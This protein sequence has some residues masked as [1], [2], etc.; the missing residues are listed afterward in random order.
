MATRTASGVVGMTPGSRPRGRLIALEGIDGSGKS[1]V[2]PALGQ[3]LRKEGWTV[4]LRHEPADRSLGLLAQSASARD[5]WTG[6]IYFTIVRHLAR[7]ALDRDLATHDVVLTDRS[8]FSTLAYQGSALRPRDRRRLERLQRRVTVA[9][10]RVVLLDLDP[11]EALRRIGVRRE[12]R[13]PLERRAVLGRVAEAY[14]ALARRPGWVVVDAR[15]PREELVRALVARLRRTL[16]EP[17]RRPSL[18]PRRRRR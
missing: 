18:G 15:L 4:A 5:P 13:T 12:R 3:A 2:T 1:T 9:P 14:R 10:D 6:A 16:P 8:F 7:S 11:A 17:R